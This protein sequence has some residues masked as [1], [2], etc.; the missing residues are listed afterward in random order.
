MFFWQQCKKEME[1][2]TISRV[3]GTDL[4]SLERHHEL[5]ISWRLISKEIKS[6]ASGFGEMVTRGSRLYLFWLPYC[7]LAAC[8]SN[9]SVWKALHV[10]RVRVRISSWQVSRRQCTPQQL[11]LNLTLFVLFPRWPAQSESTSGCATQSH[12]P[13]MLPCVSLSLSTCIICLWFEAGLGSVDHGLKAS[14]QE[15]EERMNKIIHHGFIA[16]GLLLF[17]P[18]RYIY[19]CVWYL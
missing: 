11:C 10:L 4:T 15:Q 13:L 14:N 8:R 5:F 3:W 1:N 12:R 6:V 2:K 18:L 16:A 17:S 19:E 7:Y 9:K